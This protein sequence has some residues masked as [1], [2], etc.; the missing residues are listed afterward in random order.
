MYFL[1]DFGNISPGQP[2]ET[3]I[4]ALTFYF[5]LQ[6]V[7]EEEKQEH[8]EKVKDLL[9]WVSTLARNTQGTTTSSRTS[10]STDI[11]KAIL[12]QQVSRKPIALCTGGVLHGTG[13]MAAPKTILTLEKTG[14]KTITPSAAWVFIYLFKHLSPI[15]NCID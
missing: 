14:S 1:S 12:E 15:Y 8:V 5:L 9:G 3:L 7:V 2:S 13:P 6:K 10:A 4:T 11:E